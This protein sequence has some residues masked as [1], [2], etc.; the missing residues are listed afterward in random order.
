MDS[1]WSMFTKYD[2]V[3]QSM[4][5]DLNEKDDLDMYEE[6]ND[7]ELLKLDFLINK[8]DCFSEED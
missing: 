5:G 8:I 3:I 1:K 2:G 4:K 7:F 6:N